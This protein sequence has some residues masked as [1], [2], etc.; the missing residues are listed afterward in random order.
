MT[1]ENSAGGAETPPAEAA[2]RPHDHL[3]ESLIDRLPGRVQTS[4]RWL[5]RP[6]SWWA[7]VPA[8][9]LLVIGGILS[10]LPLL[11]IWMLPLGLMLA[12]ADL[13]KLGFAHDP[14]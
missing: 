12:H 9:V 4:I 2:A 1:P 10:I 6:D 13:V 7:R 8:G 5:R 11:G 3:V 14:R